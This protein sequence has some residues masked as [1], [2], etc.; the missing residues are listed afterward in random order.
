MRIAFKGFWPISKLR[1]GILLFLAVLF[2]AVFVLDWSARKEGLYF[3]YLPRPGLC[4]EKE[5]CF[6]PGYK[7][8]I[9]LM[10]FYEDGTFDLRIERENSSGVIRRIQ[11][12]EGASGVYHIK[13]TFADGSSCIVDQNK[14][15]LEKGEVR[16]VE[17]YHND[18]L[19]LAVGLIE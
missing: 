16:E 9:L 8:S 13:Q 14:E 10:D 4:V 19:I 6:L 2:L 12:L 3:V 18:T 1:V 15:C 7:H 5:L 17:Y 11:K